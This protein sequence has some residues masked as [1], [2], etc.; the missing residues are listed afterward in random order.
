MPICGAK[1]R[2]VLY[3]E[4]GDGGKGNNSGDPLEQKWLVTERNCVLA[5][6]SRNRKKVYVEELEAKVA[7]LET[8]VHQ[9]RSE[10]HSLK[11]ECSSTSTV[12]RA[13]RK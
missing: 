2:S 13:W 1:R 3:E 5:T 8:S 9:L 12:R 11:Q 10:N 4:E 7:T 6:M